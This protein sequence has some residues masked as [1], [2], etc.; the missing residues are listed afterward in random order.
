VEHVPYVLCPLRRRVKVEWWNSIV[1]LAEILWRLETPP[2]L[3][4]LSNHQLCEGCIVLTASSCPLSVQ[5]ST[6]FAMHCQC[7]LGSFRASTLAKGRTLPIMAL[8]ISMGYPCKPGVTDLCPTKMS[9]DI[10][11]FSL[12]LLAA[13]YSRC[14]LSFTR[15]DIR[16]LT[17][18]PSWTL[19]FPHNRCNGY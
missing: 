17:T 16:V 1:Q 6:G 2:S 5:T 14:P 13:G 4:P 10:M 18:G 8:L 9:T 11:P 12:G 19:S 3:F 15:R 7:Y